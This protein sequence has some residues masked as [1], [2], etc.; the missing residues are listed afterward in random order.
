[1]SSQEHA[2][3]EF[4]LRSR[5]AELEVT[6]HNLSQERSGLLARAATAEQHL[7][8]EIAA[9][10]GSQAELSEMQSLLSSEA[11]ARRGAQEAAAKAARD[12]AEHAGLAAEARARAQA[13]QSEVSEIAISV[14]P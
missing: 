12:A 2:A 5:V 9:H 7:R 10:Q 11:G 3:A 4:S 13:L 14:A 1:M 6:N 8:A